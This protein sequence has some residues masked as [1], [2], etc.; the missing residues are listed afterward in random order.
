MK[1]SRDKI[2]R[3]TRKLNILS[4]SPGE[5]GQFCNWKKDIY[6]EEKAFPHL[7]PYGTGGYLSSCLDSGEN[8]GFAVYCRNRLKSAN[9]KYRNDQTYV[10]FLFLVKESMELILQGN[11]FKTSKKHTRTN[12]GFL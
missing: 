5:K 9:P 8:M 4:V 10:F 6:I 1:M 12:K 3:V 11:I 2:E 7:F